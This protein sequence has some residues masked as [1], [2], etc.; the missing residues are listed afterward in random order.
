LTQLAP[1]AL[2]VYNR[3]KHT[4]QTVEALLLNHQSKESDLY[5]FSDAPKNEAA[6]DAVEEVRVYIKQISGFN[7]VNIV[8]RDVN[9]GLANSVI[10]GVTKLCDEFDSVIV[11]EDDL[12]VSPN[13]LEF[14]NSGL[15]KYEFDEKVMQIAGYMFPV[16][17]ETSDDALFMPLTSSWGWATWKRAWTHFDADAKGYELLVNNSQ[18]R[19]SFNINGKY[20]YFKMLESQKSNKVDSWAIRWYLSV[21]LVNGLVLYPRKSLVQ[22]LGFD[23][24]GVNCIA[25]GFPEISIDNNFIVSRMPIERE[26]SK[27]YSEII[28][29]M[30]KPKFSFKSYFNRL[31]KAFKV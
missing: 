30:P 27:Y 5:I 23:G 25:S 2:F 1:I 4:R 18:L 9:R 15:A 28:R 17:I 31:K 11:L 22:N 19:R 10:N 29:Q 3:P 24:S 7:N 14:M 12:V 8:E 20:P 16:E 13:F 26:I 6:R 21:F